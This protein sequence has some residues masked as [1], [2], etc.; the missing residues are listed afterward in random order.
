MTPTRMAISPLMSSRPKARTS[1]LSRRLTSMGMDGWTRTNS[2]NTSPGRRRI[3]PRPGPGKARSPSLPSPRPDTSLSRR[4]LS[5]TP[6]VMPPNRHQEERAGP[7]P[8][9]PHASTPAIFGR[10]SDMKQEIRY[11]V[12]VAALLGLSLAG[13][14]KKDEAP[15]PEMPAPEAPAPQATPA[16]PAPMA[17]PAPGTAPAPMEAA[18]AESAPGAAAPAEPAPAETPSAEPAK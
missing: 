12:L 5:G 4:L 8:R 13:C 7:W 9:R 10:R 2:T 6:A 3:S 17:E 16:E 14:Q 1:W 18:P 15:V 11:S